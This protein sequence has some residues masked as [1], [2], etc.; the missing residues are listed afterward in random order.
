MDMNKN[1]KGHRGMSFCCREKIKKRLQIPRRYKSGRTS[2]CALSKG[3][4]TLEA[5]LALPFLLCTVVSL[6]WLFS[7]TV[8]QAKESRSLME[9][10]QLLAVTVASDTADPYVRLYG[11]DHA[12]FSFM[13]NSFGG[14]R[15]VRQAVV[16]AWVGYTGESFR[17]GQSDE[18]VFITPEGT[19]Y[20]RSR[21]CT[22]L[23][24]SIRQ[25]PYNA[26]EDARN[27]S[28]G[29]YAPCEYCIHSG[30]SGSTVYITNYGNRY[31]STKNCRGLK[32]TVMAVPL[33]EVG[34]RR[35]CSR[36]G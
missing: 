12:A 16:R 2:F 19:V 10:A 25:L 27:Q 7:F 24:L 21:D 17:T 14:G 31:H 4:M 23:R 13:S 6:L 33:S 34:G 11:S 29:K 30:W 3:S 5:S 26:L 22:Y 9:R 18:I 8:I 36:C 35:C 32:R 15:T 28:G 20:H 1:K